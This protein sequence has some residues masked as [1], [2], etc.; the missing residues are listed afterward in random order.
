MKISKV[1]YSDLEVLFRFTSDIGSFIQL[2]IE[3]IR[4]TDN[5]KKIRLTADYYLAKEL[6]KRFASKMLNIEGNKKCTLTLKPYEAVLFID[7]LFICNQ[8]GGYGLV[9]YEKCIMHLYKELLTQNI[10]PK[11]D[12][13]N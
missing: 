5:I 4:P 1:T 12:Y 6:A 7:Y 10:T 9:V 2:E 13:R 11:N 8:V 3:T